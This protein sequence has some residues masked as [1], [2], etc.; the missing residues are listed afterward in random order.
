MEDKIKV[1][2]IEDDESQLDY[3]FSGESVKV[4]DVDESNLMIVTTVHKASTGESHSIWSR[5]MTPVEVAKYRIEKEKKNDDSK[6]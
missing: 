4:G 1:S 5:E 2:K 6:I 3:K